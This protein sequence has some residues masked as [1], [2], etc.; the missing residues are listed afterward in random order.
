M[1]TANQRSTSIK[2][3]FAVSIAVSFNSSSPSNASNTLS[4][5]QR[6]GKPKGKHFLFIHFEVCCH[7][8]YLA[9]TKSLIF[10]IGLFFTFKAYNLSRQSSIVEIK[11][12]QVKIW[13]NTV[14]E[15][16]FNQK[17]HIQWDCQNLIVTPHVVLPKFDGMVDMVD[18]LIFKNGV[19]ALCLSS[20]CL[21][22]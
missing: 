12:R 14:N 22:F 10:Q 6:V 1:L 21:D 5:S 15:F 13:Y 4:A 16:I 8:N 11:S 2:F 3:A 9:R 18:I 20:F 7:L 19:Q 17:S